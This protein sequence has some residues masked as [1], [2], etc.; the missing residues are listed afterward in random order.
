MKRTIK[1]ILGL[2]VVVPVLLLLSSW[3]ALS[4]PGHDWLARLAMNLVPGLQIENLHGRLPFAPRIGRAVLSDSQGPYLVLE[5]VALDL[6]LLRLASGELRVSNLTAE[7]VV[8]SRLPVADP[9]APAPARESGSLLPQLPQLPVTVALEKAAF[10]R[11]ELGAAVAGSAATLSLE[12]GGRLG[13][14]GVFLGVKGRR[15]DAPGALDLDLALAPGDRVKIDLAYDE[16]SGGLVAALLGRPEQTIQL[17][18]A[19]DGPASGAA[20]TVSADMGDTARVQASGTLSLPA[21]GGVGLEATGEAALGGFLPAPVSAL[22][23][24]IRTSPAEGGATRIERAQVETAV[25]TIQAQGLVGNSLDV[26]FDARLGDS[27]SL[28]D[29]VPASVGWGAIEARGAV[30]GTNAAPELRLEATV[31]DPRLPEP[32]PGL[33]GPAPTLLLRANQQRV[34]ELVVNGRALN[35]RAEGAYGEILDLTVNAA[36]SA[37]DIPN[38]PVQGQLEAQ[39]RITGPRADP[40]VALTATSPALEAYGRRFEAIRLEASL[41]RATVPAGNLTLN[42]RLQGLPLAV[43]ARAAQEGGELRVETLRASLGPA[44]VEASGRVDLASFLAE[45]ELRLEAPNLAPLSPVA[46]TPLGGGLRVE[47]KLSPQGEG[48]ARRQGIVAEIRA[49]DLRAAGQTINGTVNASGTD[50]SLDVRGDLRALDGRATLRARLALDQPDKRIELSALDVQRQALG[51][52]LSAPAT[53][54]IGAD[55]GISTPGLS[56]Q[57]RPGGTLRIVGRWGPE[58]A[59][60]RATI[61]SLPLSI[62]NIFVPDPPLSGTIAGEVRLSGPVARPAIEGELRGTGIRSGA[63]WARGLPEGSLQATARMRGDAVEARAEFR[64]G[65]ALRLNLEARVPS[66]FTGPIS[67]TLRGTTD[68]G[69]LAAPFLLGGA[70]RVAGT[71]AIDARASGTVAEPQISGTARLSGGLYRNLEYGLALR[72]IQGTIRGDMDRIVVESITAQAGPGTLRA[73]GEIRPFAEGQPVDIRVSGQN[74]QPVSS[75]LL[76]G[77]FDADLRLTGSVG[78]GMR[79]AGAV[80]V[81]NATI[82][83]AEG[84]PGGVAEIGEVREVGRGAPAPRPG[85][86]AARRR[87]GRQPAPAAANP[88]APP[89]AL[90]ITVRA[91]GQVYL[92]GRG[93]DAELAGEVRIR[94][95]ISDPEATG[96]LRLR[97][98][99]LTV[100]DRRLTF[101]RGV[102]TFQ[103]DITSPDIDLLATSRAGST[104]INVTVTGTPAAPKIEFSSSP[105]LPQDEVLAQLLFNRPTDRLS[106]FQIAQLARVLSGA[107]SGGQEDPVSGLLGR[108]SRTLGLD[109]LGIGTGAGG[110]PGIEAGGYLGQ[111]IYLNVDPGTTNGTPRVGV[112]IELTPRLKLESGAGADSQGLGLT[113]EYEY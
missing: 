6:S 111:G 84:L 112:E 95:T 75:D 42:A 5:D 81:R 49:N 7:R 101:Q 45:A 53:V 74:L 113:Y 85:T 108:V 105:E 78:D 16:P 37:Q 97:R 66:D 107:V 41:P 47:A 29:L 44:R 64:V 33:L 17:R 93:L 80:T 39:A 24:D 22:R 86:V 28:G 38:V 73:Q 34:H 21:E 2:V 56:L 79:L 71:V 65:P 48:E 55:G 40:A 98:G 35:I 68:I 10:P 59:D 94:G 1:A 31:R 89:L 102:L 60:L 36:L 43:E 63:P 32:A 99:T 51:I 109:R 8:F 9:D 58:N 50:A 18:V 11:I 106:P 54:V 110:T 104:T 15:L 30:T 27:T 19:L 26:T 87:A 96:A 83:I 14:D 23:F 103:G 20:L 88:A 46:G 69:V 12:V 61:G 70:S 91:P 82:G 92:R 3:T 77:A 25:G 13:D 52:R 4:A 57:G 67:G 72:N 76:R 62:V 100:L 90:D